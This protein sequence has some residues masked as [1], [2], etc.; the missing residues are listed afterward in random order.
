[1]SYVL[2]FFNRRHSSETLV[3]AQHWKIHKANDTFQYYVDE[4]AASECQHFAV[5]LGAVDSCCLGLFNGS[6]RP[7]QQF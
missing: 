2:N 1:M 3:L 4:M 6:Y 7:K 5:S